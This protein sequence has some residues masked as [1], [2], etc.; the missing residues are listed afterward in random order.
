MK[1]NVYSVYDAK[2]QVYNNP[3]YSPTNGSAIRS[4]I[5]LANS[6]DTLIGKFPDDFSLISLS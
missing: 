4:F 6:K 3:F 2:S 1:Q 5:E